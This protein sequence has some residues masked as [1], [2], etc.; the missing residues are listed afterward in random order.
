M[1][2]DAY[3]WTLERRNSS[4]LMKHENQPTQCIGNLVNMNS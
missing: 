4:E 2:F 3:G 1:E